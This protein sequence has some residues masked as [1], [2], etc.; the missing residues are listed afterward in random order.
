M[1][2]TSQ[3]NKPG[4]DI[5]FDTKYLPQQSLFHTIGKPDAKKA[6]FFK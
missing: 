4:P 2:S 6:F 3:I 5:L 1:Q